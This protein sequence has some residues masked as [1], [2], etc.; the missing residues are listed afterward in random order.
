MK[1]KKA[2]QE[3]IFNERWDFYYTAVSITSCSAIAGNA[4]T[5]DANDLAGDE[6]SSGHAEER[7]RG[8]V[9]TSCDM[10][11][12]F[13]IHCFLGGGKNKIKG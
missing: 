2:Y 10:A 8:M 5:V 4:A 12:T 3:A 13:F 1:I 6:G 7:R 9:E 11:P